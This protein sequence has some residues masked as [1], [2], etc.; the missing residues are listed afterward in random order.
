MSNHTDQLFRTA[1]QHHQ[2]GRLRDAEQLYRQVLNRQPKHADALHLLGV[3]AHQGGHHEVAVKLIRQA[4]AVTPNAAPYFGNLGNAFKSLGQLDQAI[5]A[6]RR[7]ISL[8]PNHPPSHSNLGNALAA[9]GQ[10][11]EAIAAYRKAID[12]KP[13]YAEAHYNLGKTQ[14]DAGQ[15]DDAIGTYRRAVELQPSF[16]QAYSNLGSALAKAGRLDES[17]AACHKAIALEPRHAPAFSNLGFVLLK[18]GRPDEAIAACEKAIALQPDLEL[19]HNNLGNAL[20]RKGLRDRAIAA[21]RQATVIRPNDAQAHAN[22]GSALN[23]AWLLDDAIDACRRAIE[24]NPALPEAPY[25]LGNVLKHKGKQEAAAAAYRKAVELRPDFAEAHVNLAYLLHYHPG[26][27]PQAV[28]EEHARWS[29]RHAKPLEN[30]IQPHGNRRDPERRLRIGYVSPDFRQHPVSRFFLPVIGRHDRERFEV[31]CYS[32]V[33]DPDATTGQI[34]ARADHW[35]DIAGLTDA[36]VADVI[37]NDQID[38]LVDLAG[39][40]ADNRLLAFARKPAPVQVTYLGY[41]GSTGLT[42]IDYRLTDALA[43]PPGLT[44]SLHSEQLVRL[45]EC[46]W[47]YEPGDTP[48]PAPRPDRPITFGCFNNFAKITEPVLDLWARILKEVP[49]SMLLLKGLALMQES[50]RQSVYRHFESLGIERNRLELLGLSTSHH[51]HLALYNRMDI[52]LDTFPY[53]GT[54]TTCEALWM[55]V[56]VVTL[57]GQSHASRVGV[58]LLTNVGLAELVARDTGQYVEIAAGLVGAPS[59]LADL[60]GTLRERMRRSPL[61]DAVQ[62]TRNVEAAYRS[63]WTDWCGGIQ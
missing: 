57:A 19:V 22:L 24:L 3:V 55:G 8:R 27:S 25:N 53:H 26:V 31:H 54:T 63:V 12:L 58:S 35:H 1:V 17:A 41:P 10:L 47:C 20:L 15:L 59:C 34:R 40:T 45:S 9:N 16:F 28:F 48:D 7:S 50:S 60:R 39:H 23:D 49:D 61:M 43:D 30:P 18:L 42:A 32:D 11:A 36:Q 46:A 29:E 5:T 52:A 38:I 21:F 13:D 14:E 56:P 4:T 33:A 44:E 6:Y 51:E 2:A 37:R 62:F